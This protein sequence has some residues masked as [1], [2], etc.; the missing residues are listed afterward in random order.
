MP[1]KQTSKQAFQTPKPKPA[2]PK[3]KGQTLNAKS[4]N[5]AVLTTARRLF[6]LVKRRRAGLRGIAVEGFWLRLEVTI[7]ES[8]SPRV[9]CRAMTLA[10]PPPAICQGVGV[11]RWWLG[12][13]G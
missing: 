11:E 1:G 6:E 7:D 8:L 2:T 4:L 12:V 3:A 10:L 9:E 5:R 13:G